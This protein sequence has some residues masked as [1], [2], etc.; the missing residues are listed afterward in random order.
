M[1]VSLS[2]LASYFS[3]VIKLNHGVI[4]LRKIYFIKF[5]TNQSI[6]VYARTQKCDES[7][8]LYAHSRK[9]LD[10]TSEGKNQ[11]CHFKRSANRQF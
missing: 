8:S 7:L 1:S 3:I 2:A 5:T 9:E 11:L 6:K 4:S 10:V